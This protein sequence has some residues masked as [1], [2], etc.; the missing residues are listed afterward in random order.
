MIAAMLLEIF[1][2]LADK[3]GNEAHHAPGVQLFRRDE[4]VTSVFLLDAGEVKLARP[5]PEDRELILQHARGPVILAEASLYSEC[6]DCDAICL[7]ACQVRV[8]PAERFL[9]LIEESAVLSAAW[10]AHL[11]RSLEETRIRAEILTLKTA[12]ERLEAWFAWRGAQE[13]P[14]EKRELLAA[15][16][17]VSLR[18]LTRALAQRRG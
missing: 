12:R 10:G 13:P 8:L 5:L 1:E 4:E 17:G 16:L 18:T 15:E 6:Y 14:Q 2:A 11:A 3:A 7:T 9:S